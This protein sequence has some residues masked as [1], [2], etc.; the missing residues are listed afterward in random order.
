[1][2]KK[3]SLKTYF[4]YPNALEFM[5]YSLKSYV[6]IQLCR[7]YILKLVFKNSLHFTLLKISLAKI[8]KM[9]SATQ[10]RMLWRTIIA[11]ILCI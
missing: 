6:H 7:I 2:V 5:I 8:E 3:K 9:L 11:F 1:M 10:D 4:I